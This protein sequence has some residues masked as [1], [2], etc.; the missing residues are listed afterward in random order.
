[1][2]QRYPRASTLLLRHS[3]D[4]E[5][6]GLPTQW[7]TVLLLLLVNRSRRI[8]RVV[9]ALRSDAG[10]TCPSTE[11]GSLACAYLSASR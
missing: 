5:R 3:H 6:Q 11:A 10:T 7:L 2:R 1:M 9:L 4:H 8:C